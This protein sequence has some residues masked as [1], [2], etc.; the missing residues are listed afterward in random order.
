MSLLADAHIK[1]D[2]AESLA[3]LDA[4]FGD[5]RQLYKLHKLV[6][7]IDGSWHGVVNVSHSGTDGEA[8][9]GAFYLLA[10][11]VPINVELVFDSMS[12]SVQLV[13]YTKDFDLKALLRKAKAFNYSFF[14]LPTLQYRSLFI[15]SQSVCSRWW[16]LN[17]G[18]AGT[19]YSLMRACNAL[20][21][22]L[23]KDPELR[24]LDNGLR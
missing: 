1:H 2:L 9:S 13:W 21:L 6:G 20:E 17:Q 14:Q 7:R 16:R 12:G 8:Q 23:Y 11:K 4:Q 5:A 10:R 19:P 22:M 3:T 24:T 15:P 18:L